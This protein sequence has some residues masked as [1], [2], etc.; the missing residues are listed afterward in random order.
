MNVIPVLQNVIFSSCDTPGLHCLPMPIHSRDARRRRVNMPELKGP[1]EQTIPK[2]DK[3]SVLAKPSSCFSRF[4]QIL[5]RCDNRSL[6][7]QVRY[8]GIV[9]TGKHTLVNWT[10]GPTVA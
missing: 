10:L 1:S 3:R 9:R 7:V 5:R 2:F 4:S 8:V 6:R